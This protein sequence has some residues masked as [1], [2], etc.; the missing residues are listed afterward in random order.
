QL[1]AEHDEKM[2]ILSDEGGIFDILG[3]RYSN[4]IPNID[5]FLQAYSGTA[6]RVDRGSRPSIFL[7]RPALTLVLSPQPSVLR[8]LA[9]VPG[10]R[11]RGLLAR[12]LYALPQSTLGFRSLHAHPIP[13]S[14][15]ASYY[16]HITVLLRLLP[17]VDGCPYQ[18]RFA[19]AA[20]D[21]WKD[22]QR[23]VELE[24]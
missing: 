2:A 14:V 13:E 23:H 15:R 17:Q 16:K 24:M 10:F 7:Q 20:Y 1:L 9:A 4:G 22:F 11:G 5:L 19:Q 18:V 8:D 12:P 3:G 6:Y 21:Q